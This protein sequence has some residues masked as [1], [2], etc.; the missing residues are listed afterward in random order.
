MLLS[1]P[2]L[3]IKILIAL[4]IGNV[5]HLAKNPADDLDLVLKASANK[6]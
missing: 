3:I 1:C 4:L 2:A 6:F 5:H